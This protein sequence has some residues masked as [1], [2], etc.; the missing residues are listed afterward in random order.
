MCGLTELVHAI[1]QQLVHSKFELDRTL[2][3]LD[4]TFI[5]LDCALIELDR[6]LI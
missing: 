2:I 5:E 1:C 3:E 4:R 6:N